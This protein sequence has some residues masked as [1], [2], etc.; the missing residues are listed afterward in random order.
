MR[1]RTSVPSDPHHYGSQNKPPSHTGNRAGGPNNTIENVSS[2]HTLS[3]HH[4]HMDSKTLD[5]STPAHFADSI[6]RL[7]VAQI[8]QSTGYRAATSSSL[9]TLARLATLHLRSLSSSASQS[10][11]LSRRSQPNLLDFVSAIERLSFP[12]G[13]PG[14]SLPHFQGNP[15]L[16]GAVKELRDFVCFYSKETPFAK[17]IPRRCIQENV[18]APARSTSYDDCDRGRP[19]I[20]GW[21]PGF[22]EAEREERE[23]ARRKEAY[24]EDVAE[25]SG[26]REEKRVEK[27]K[28]VLPWRRERVKFKFRG[29]VKNKQK[30]S[31][32]VGIDLKLKRKRVCLD[33]SGKGIMG[34]D[35]NDGT[36]V[37]DSLDDGKVLDV[38]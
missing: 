24:W 3:H 17:P 10:S 32:V 30:K 28:G 8:I 21:L 4:P 14:A 33:G 29:V 23:G 6:A 25:T 20:P 36:K 1:I 26:R 19:E 7:A 31:G 18:V 15:F 12:R 34:C 16:C 35:Q 27:E 38:L 22:P 5:S 13:F 11:A 37:F 2:P 9:E